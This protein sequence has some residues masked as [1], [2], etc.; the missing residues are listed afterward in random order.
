M[1]KQKA[2]YVGPDGFVN[3]DVARE[4]RK[5]SRMKHGETYEVSEELFAGL[6]AG[7]GWEP[8]GRAAEEAAKKAREAALAESQAANLGAPEGMSYDELVASQEEEA[9]RMAEEAQQ[10]QGG[11][12][13]AAQQSEPR[14]ATPASRVEQTGGDDS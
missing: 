14:P 8:D 11:E 6:I 5:G 2:R 12:G 7:G 4:T 3:L 1:A 10:A 9:Q 13:Q